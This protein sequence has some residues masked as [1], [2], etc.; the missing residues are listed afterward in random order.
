MVRLAT[1]ADNGD[2]PFAAFEALLAAEYPRAHARLTLEKVGDRGLLYRWKGVASDRPV[3]LMAH[4]DVVPADESWNPFSGEIRDGIVWGRGTLDDKGPLL[5][6]LEAVENLVADNVVPAHD[7]Y[8]SF[9]GNEESYGTAARQIAELFRERGITPWLVLD[10]GGAVVDAPL[11]YLPVPAAMVGVGE[12][13]VMTVRL[14]ARSDGGHASAP[15]TR[16]PASRLARALL[17]LERNPFPTRMPKPFRQ[18]IARFEPYVSARHRVALRLLRTLHGPAA[19]IHAAQGGEAAAIMG[20]TIVT[21]MLEGGSAPN[22]LPSA[23]SAVLNIRIAVGESVESVLATI[24]RTIADDSV[25]IDVDEASEPSPMSPTGN[26]QFALIAGAVA[27]SYPEAVTAP[28]VTLA[29][30]DSRHFHRF[31]PAVYRFAPLRM[32]AAQ[33]AAIHGENE[34][35]SID[36]LERGERFFQVLIRSL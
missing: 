31:S 10:E 22:V 14:T 32:T 28:Y 16:P 8:L 34:H 4:Y 18:M 23:L 12:K 11:R 25:T 17:L 29:A 2:E 35:V 13:G 33:R 1:T 7:V 3:V 30:T 6:I 5:V 9:G 19:R 27:A 15:P 20:T 26:E 36:S 21:T 24:R